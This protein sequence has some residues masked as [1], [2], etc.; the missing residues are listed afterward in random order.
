MT[1]YYLLVSLILIFPFS[2]YLYY[3]NHLYCLY[4]K[5]IIFKFGRK[6]ISSDKIYII[7]IAFIMILIS[8]FRNLN[9]GNDTIAYYKLYTLY[10]N[11]NLIDIINMD[12]KEPGFYILS[13]LC[14]SLGMSYRFFLLTVA[15]LYICAVSFI[16]YKYSYISWFSYLVFIGI[17]M[18]T[19]GMTAIRQTLAISFTLITYYKLDTGKIFQSLL[20]MIIAYLCHVTA[21][22]FLPTYFLIKLS[23]NKRNLFL[24]IVICVLIYLNKAEIIN[25]F[26]TNNTND[27]TPTETGGVITYAFYLI[28]IFISFFLTK[29]NILKSNIFF[30]ALM[31]L[32]LWPVMSFHPAVFRLGNYYS[33]FFII[34]IPNMIKSMIDDLEKNVGYIFCFFY[35]LLMLFMFFYNVLGSNS[36]FVPYIFGGGL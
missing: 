19:F 23:L 3:S 17:G 33:I 32:V 34:L 15:M 20:F 21:V 12:L 31:V 2:M 10:S 6:K 5:N 27:Y 16:I 30:M 13:S 22:V 14:G 35:V 11:M 26:V 4:S 1:I 36:A 18:M 8:G 24:M 28:T 9:I 29:K 25:F 7:F